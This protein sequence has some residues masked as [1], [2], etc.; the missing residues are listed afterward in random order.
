MRTAV[1]R[2]PNT[3]TTPW[4][5]ALTPRQ[6]HTH[7]DVRLCNHAFPGEDVGD[8]LPEAANKVEQFADAVHLLA[9]ACERGDRQC[10]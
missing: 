5:V 3:D 8:F 1:A 6:H 2:D 10:W 4:L 9:H 7:R